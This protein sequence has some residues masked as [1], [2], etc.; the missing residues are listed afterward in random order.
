MVTF[1]KEHAPILIPCGGTLASHRTHAYRDIVN[2]ESMVEKPVGLF[3][4]YNESHVVKM[5]I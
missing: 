1:A 2:R 4:L 5:I 3:S